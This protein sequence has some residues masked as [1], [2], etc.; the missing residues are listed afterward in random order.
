MDR[1][2][3]MTTSSTSSE[4]EVIVSEKLSIIDED[5]KK[6]QLYIIYSNWSLIRIDKEIKN[7]GDIGL[8]RIICSE[9]KETNRTLALLE[10][11]VYYKLC[12]KGYSA[13]KN[14][15]GFSIARFNEKALDSPPKG[16]SRN[17]FVP[18]PEIFRKDDMKTID[19]ID[20]KLKH[21]VE[22]EVL[23]ENSWHVNALL[24]SRE[25]G[26]ISSGCFIVFDNKVDLKTI[27][28]VKV[29]ITDTCWPKVSSDLEREQFKCLWAFDSKRKDHKD[30]KKSKPKSKKYERKSKFS[31]KDSSDSSSESSDSSD[32]DSSDEKEKKRSRKIK[33]RKIKSEEKD[34]KKPLRKIK[35]EEKEEKIPSRKIK[36]EEKEKKSSRKIK[37]EE[38]E[39]KEEKKQSRKI[40][41]EWV[42]K[43]SEEKVEVE[44]EDKVVN[45]VVTSIPKIP[46]PVEISG[47]VANYEDDS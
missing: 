19:I 22:W 20:E 3:E 46:K 17:L 2:T 26:E 44:A 35:S 5:D 47:D 14:G 15:K 39:E 33:P 13:K 11:D 23:S 38:K 24:E 31:R 37:S 45:N 10:N 40:K 6:P 4:E 18:V 36:S 8:L 30:D 41:S 25:K 28:K 42:E 34:E 1:K 16:C 29:I 32:S 12:E 43:K 21:L 27:A 9:G 7:F